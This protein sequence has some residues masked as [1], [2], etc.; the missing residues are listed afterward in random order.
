MTMHCVAG[1]SAGVYSPMGPSQ[2][3]MQPA[4]GSAYERVDDPFAAAYAP[5]PRHHPPA[6]QSVPAGS[7]H[8]PVPAAPGS[9]SAGGNMV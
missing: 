2:P 1:E 4:I 9:L 5:P 8:P 7:F 6:T 3:A